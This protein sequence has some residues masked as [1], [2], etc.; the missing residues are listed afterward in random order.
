MKVSAAK[1]DGFIARPNSEIALILLFGPDAGLV[2]ER[3][4][5]LVALTAENPKDPFRVADL[6]GPEL[7]KD[8]ARLV[9]EA[10][11]FSMTGGKR[12]VRV[13][14]AA[15]SLVGAVKGLMANP[16]PDVSLVVLEAGDLPPRSS[17]RK[18]CEADT[19]AA[20]VPCYLPDAGAIADLAREI[21]SAAGLRIDDEAL[22]YLADSLQGDRQLA[23]RELDKLVSYV[24]A[25]PTISG[26]DARA[27]I[28]DSTE[29]SVDDALMAVAGGRIDDADR[30]LQ[31][32]WSEGVN[33]IAVLRAAQRHF[34]RLHQARTDMENGAGVE[35]AMGR[36]R[37]PVFFKLQAPVRRQLRIWPPN[38]L[39]KALER[40]METEAACKRTG[41][42]AELLTTR[43]LFGLTVQAARTR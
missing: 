43:I 41:A 3:A 7:A 9:D 28:G 38:A 18:F 2:R 14:D 10:G 33:A 27:C 31:K 11:A 37:P 22:T 15:D 36:L 13:R 21:A 34:G 5:K 35:Q 20:A 24:G 23:R 29:R 1:S 19:S 12:A 39:S 8:P 40:L 6:A 42:P 32:L 4:A 26:D 16:M 17:L 25:G 30:V